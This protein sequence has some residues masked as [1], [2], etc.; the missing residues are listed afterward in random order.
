MMIIRH[1]WHQEE[2][3]IQQ[4][5]SAGVSFVTSRIARSKNRPRQ[6]DLQKRENDFFEEW[7]SFD[8]DSDL[9][10]DWVDNGR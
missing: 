8:D 3:Q 4:K 6:N 2:V 7:K 1:R 10:L 9:E 5:P